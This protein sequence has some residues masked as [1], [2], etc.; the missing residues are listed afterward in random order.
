MMEIA[1][2]RMTLRILPMVTD[3][4]NGTIDLRNPWDHFGSNELVKL[5]ARSYLKGVKVSRYYTHKGGDGND[6]II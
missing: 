3:H 6:H 1:Y 2:R 5:V 4:P